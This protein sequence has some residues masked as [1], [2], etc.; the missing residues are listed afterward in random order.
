MWV[1]G[2]A[3][4]PCTRGSRE[5][6]QVTVSELTRTVRQALGQML[7]APYRADYL[8]VTR[9]CVYASLHGACVRGVQGSYLP[10]E[11]LIFFV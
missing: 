11:K 6:G 8:R 3:V 5:Q 10:G 2:G 7:K 1:V 4:S 9:T